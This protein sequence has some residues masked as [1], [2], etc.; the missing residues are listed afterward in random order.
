MAYISILQSK[1]TSVYQ[2]DY[3]VSLAVYIYVYCL[4]NGVRF[5]KADI[6]EGSETKLAGSICSLQS[7]DWDVVRKNG[8]TLK[9]ATILISFQSFSCRCCLPPGGNQLFCDR[10]IFTFLLTFQFISRDVQV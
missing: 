9:K 5:W 2:V 1:A 3:S 10:F 7:I 8:C 6:V 4:G